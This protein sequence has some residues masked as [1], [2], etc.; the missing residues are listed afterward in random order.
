MAAD[1][2]LDAASHAVENSL[3]GKE[4][5]ECQ[6]ALLDAFQYYL[7]VVPATASFWVAEDGNMSWC[8]GV[9]ADDLLRVHNDQQQAVTGPLQLQLSTILCRGAAYLCWWLC[10]QGNRL[11]RLLVSSGT[12]SSASSRLRC[13]DLGSASD[14]EEQQLLQQASIVTQCWEVTQ[15]LLQLATH[16]QP[17][18]LGSHNSSNDPVSQ[19]FITK[20]TTGLSSLIHKQQQQLLGSILAVVNAMPGTPAAAC[21]AQV[22]HHLNQDC[23]YQ[24]LWLQLASGVIN[25]SLSIGNLPAVQLHSQQI[26]RQPPPAPQPSSITYDRIGQLV[27]LLPWLDP[28][29]LERA[30]LQSQLQLRQPYGAGGGPVPWLQLLQAVRWLS[31]G[32]RVLVD[33]PPQQWTEYYPPHQVAWRACISLR[34]Y[35]ERVGLLGIK[36][37]YMPATLV[38]LLQLATLNGCAC[39]TGLHNLLLPEPLALRF[40]SSE[41]NSQLLSWIV[42]HGT[43]PHEKRQMQQELVRLGKRLAALLTSSDAGLPGWCKEAARLMDF[44]AAADNGSN[45][46]CRPT[47]CQDSVNSNNSKWWEEL[48]VTEEDV[49]VDESSYIKS[50]RSTMYEQVNSTL[51]GDSL[52]QALAGTTASTADYPPSAPTLD[53]TAVCKVGGGCAAETDL[54]QQQSTATEIFWMLVLLA[55]N[56][57]PAAAAATGPRGQPSAAVQLQQLLLDTIAQLAGQSRASYGRTAQSRSAT[58]L[59]LLPERLQLC[60]HKLVARSSVHA[61][62]INRHGLQFETVITELLSI[63]AGLRQPWV[64]LYCSYTG[65]E[66]P[67]WARKLPA[68]MVDQQWRTQQQPNTATADRSHTMFSIQQLLR[69]SGTLKRVST[70]QHGEPVLATSPVSLE[71]AAVSDH[72]SVAASAPKRS[73]TSD[74][75]GEE[76]DDFSDKSIKQMLDDSVAAEIELIGGQYLNSWVHWRLKCS[77][78]RALGRLR[79]Q[80]GPLERLQK[81]A[82][83]CMGADL[84]Q[85]QGKAN[86]QAATSAIC[87][88]YM[89]WY[90]DYCCPVLVS[91]CSADGSLSDLTCWCMQRAGLLSK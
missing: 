86:A 15:D 60:I 55:V 76:A 69:P 37:A 51:V 87:S 6:A 45:T 1:V 44:A 82:R 39:T 38:N 5:S 42:V 58:A 26:F 73:G 31:D 78:A 35:L 85:H 83:E 80:L 43:T 22:L 53:S 84:Q 10:D 57:R 52:D 20:A 7:C 16:L 71:A 50:R 21:S 46:S 66:A 77:L 29:W 81:E 65:S 79:R 63:S 4:G 12:V 28:D 27:L 30:V 67:R 64:V 18:L 33:Q 75:A 48:R 14:Q 19:S 91:K 89:Q 36:G 25:G 23:K 59:C 68:V 13:A 2:A 62:V 8:Q 11:L 9:P 49:D 72:V 24:E 90:L 54:L 32:R 88:K 17:L 3:R 61:S 56:N 41:G 74:E 40:L 47:S 34:D 70:P